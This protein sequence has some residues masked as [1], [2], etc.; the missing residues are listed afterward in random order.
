DEHLPSRVEEA[1]DEGEGRGLGEG[2]PSRQPP[3]AGGEG[4]RS[5]PARRPPPPVAP[6]PPRPLVERVG[7][8]AP[9]AAQRAAGEPDEHA[10]LARTRA[11]ALDGE[12]DLVD[13][14]HG[15]RITRSRW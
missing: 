10:G 12:E 7:G 14:Q 13:G 6:P 11:L 5:R 15:A 8:V 3:R 9:R 4:P 2:V 1:R